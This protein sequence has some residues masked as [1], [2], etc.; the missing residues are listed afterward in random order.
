MPTPNTTRPRGSKKI[1]TR[2]DHD[3][4]QEKAQ[5]TGDEDY[6]V[7]LSRGK[8]YW[9]RSVHVFQRQPTTNELNAYEQTGS[10]LKFKGQKAQ[11]DGSAVLAA[12]QLYDKLVAR[13]YDVLVGL[14]TYD[15]LDGAQS[16]ATVP[17]LAKRAA[18]VEWIGDVQGA[19]RMAEMEGEDEPV[20]DES[21]AD[22]EDHTGSAE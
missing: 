5:I 18:V 16:R 13:T 10:R 3:L 4:I 7:V 19:T 14:K 21:E 11:V 12:V 6:V 8:G 17:A 20:E 15:K 2:Q 1:L 9:N 22:A